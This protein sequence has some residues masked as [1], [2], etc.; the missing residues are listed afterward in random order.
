MKAICTVD[1]FVV[2]RRVRL[3]PGGE[4]QVVG[5]GAYG[6]LWETHSVSAD[7]PHAVA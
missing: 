5:K 6:T 2:F 7:A 3:A 4:S 1:S